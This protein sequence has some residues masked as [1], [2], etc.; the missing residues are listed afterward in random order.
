MTR[1]VLLLVKKVN[2]S[3]KVDIVAAKRAVSSVMRAKIAKMRLSLVGY[4]CPFKKY[5]HI[6]LC[7]CHTYIK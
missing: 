4:T 5:R 1:H 3:N 2:S 7:E 6:R